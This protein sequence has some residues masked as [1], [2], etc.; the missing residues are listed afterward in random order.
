MKENGDDVDL[1]RN[2]ED[3]YSSEDSEDEKMKKRKAKKEKKEKE[4][5]PP[6]VDLSETS[7]GKRS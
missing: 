1:P 2:F 6:V 5:L 7:F 3:A 4:K